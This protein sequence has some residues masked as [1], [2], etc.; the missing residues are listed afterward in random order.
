M[1]LE[2]FK[3]LKKELLKIIKET[4]SPEY[5]FYYIKKNYPKIDNFITEITKIDL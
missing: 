5:L 1:N 3:E 4:K 2:E